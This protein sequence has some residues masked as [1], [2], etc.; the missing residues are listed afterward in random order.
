MSPQFSWMVNDFMSGLAASGSS[1]AGA[2]RRWG[3]Q[4]TTARAMGAVLFVTEVGCVTLPEQRG[5]SGSS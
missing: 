5:I 2:A 4:S 3:E 1:V